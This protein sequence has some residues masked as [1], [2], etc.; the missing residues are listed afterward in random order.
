[1]GRIVQE[2]DL[3][4]N[5]GQAEKNVENLNKDLEQTQADLGGIEEAGDK[6]T[7]GLISGFKGMIA[8][9][10]SAITGLKTFRGALLATG[11]GAFVVAIGAVST[12]LTN[13]EEG[14]NKF[15]KWLSQIGVILGNVTDILG[16]FGNA[17]INFVTGNFDEAAE[18]I[19]AVTEGIK[20]FGEETRKEIQVAGELADMRAKA[21]KLE[22]RL[23]VER[24]KADRDRAELLEQA[25]NKEKFSVEERI[26]FLEEAGRLE[27][28]ITNKEIEAA[29]LR[30][31]AKIQENALSASTKEDLDEEA[32]LKAMLIQLET[33]KLTKQKEVTSQTIALKAEEAAALKAIEDE[34]RMAKEEQEAADLL[35]KEEAD[36]LAA[37]KK[38]ETDAIE[39]ER[40]DTIAAEKLERDKEVADREIQLEQ[41]R[42]A[43]KHSA[44][45]AIIGLFGAESAAG[46]AA[47][48]AKQ[49]MAAQE[50]ITEARKTLT[51]AALAGADAGASTAKGF[52]KT[53]SAGFPQNVPFLIAYALQAV[54]IG[55]AVAQAVGRAK[56]VGSQ[57]GGGGISVP[58]PRTPQVPTVAAPAT[59]P[60][61]TSVGGSGMNQLADAIGSQNQQPV[62]AFVVSNDVTTA[63]SLERNI[64]DG[65]SIG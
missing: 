40:L 59:P 54:G 36:K 47:L 21:D 33:A 35:K 64:V 27:E 63:Q 30:L 65:A 53:L 3:K 23:Q 45:N 11:I 29:R 15:A 42:V 12:A 2:V 31:E 34:Q 32:E 26:K 56:N 9:V 17:I 19:A 52:A 24:A 18:S 6:M 61:M 39:K 62:Q 14:Q 60:D 37:E 20:N 28:E 58:P 51:S 22:R 5:T 55:M 10:K 43:A 1:M 13:S 46:K 25:V 44:T 50:M 7:G 57:M 48:I 16:N 49:V 41:Q 4:A 8:G 38:A